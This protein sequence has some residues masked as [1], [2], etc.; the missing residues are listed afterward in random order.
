MAQPTVRSERLAGL[1]P[2]MIDFHTH[3]IDPDLPDVGATHA[4]RFPRV[5]R[6]GERSAQIVL[7]DRV[8]RSIDDTCWSTAAR[9]CD[10][11]REG[12]AVQVLS[13]IP[14]TLC[15]DQPAPGAAELARVQND[16]LAA[17]VAAAPRR[18]VALGAVPMQDPALAVT[19]LTRCVTELGFVGVEIGTRVGELELTDD[20]FTPFFDAASSLSAV[21]FIHP[22]DRDLDPRATKLG[23]AF[24]LG[25]PTETAAAGAALLSSGVVQAAPAARIVLAHGAGAL[26]ALLPRLDRGQH[27]TTAAETGGPISQTARRLWCDSLTYDDASL[28]LAVHRFGDD[29]VVLGTDYPFAAREQPAGAVL[30]HLESHL[31]QRIGTTNACALCVGRTTRTVTAGT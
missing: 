5:E 12:I 2:G 24:G 31:R 23:L 14:V 9:I 19:E 15:H 1:A 6:T 3:A 7:G 29:H 16:F 4:G 18:F 11:D 10:M 25:M 8:Y 30:A 27:L 22:V 13:P 20:Q 26:P 17:M 21:I 28:R